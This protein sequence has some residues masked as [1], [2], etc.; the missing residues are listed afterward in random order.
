[1][2]RLL[3]L[4]FVFLAL[5]A[6]PGCVLTWGVDE[7]IEQAMENQA[8]R[9]SAIDGKLFTIGQ[10][11]DRQ[12]FENH[13]DRERLLQRKAHFEL[14]FETEMTNLKKERE[15]MA[16]WETT[17]LSGISLIP[18]FGG[19]WL[20]A[21][22]ALKNSSRRDIHTLVQAIQMAREEDPAGDPFEKAFGE[23]VAKNINVLNP[24]TQKTIDQI[25]RK[26][27]A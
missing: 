23:R 6:L 17:I 25:R 4:T 7:K 3:M 14:A 1:M 15:E 9:L 24:K 2:K 8:A 21:A 18:G 22:R 16:R 12:D 10:R 20:T 19:G 26:A 11:E 5:A 27:V 13:Q